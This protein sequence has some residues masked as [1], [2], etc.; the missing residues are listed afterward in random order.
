M[1][2]GKLFG[3]PIVFRTNRDISASELQSN[4]LGHMTEYIKNGVK[5]EKMGSLFKLLVS[6]MTHMCKPYRTKCL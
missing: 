5:Y 2:P 3:R 4:I 1:F 6:F